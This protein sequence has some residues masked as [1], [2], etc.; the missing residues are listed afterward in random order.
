MYPTLSITTATPSV[1]PSFPLSPLPPADLSAPL[2]IRV[3]PSVLPPATAPAP[4]TIAQ[5]FAEVP[6]PRHPSFRHY[7]RLSDILVISLTAVRCGSKSGEAIAGFGNTKEAW[8]RSLGLQLPNGIPSHHTFRD[9][10][11]HLEPR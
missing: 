1:A 9:I 7:H 11:A 3:S 5:C 2:C 6:D 4:L 8:F 10:Y